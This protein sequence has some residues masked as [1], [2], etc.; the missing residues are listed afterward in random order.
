MPV[1]LRSSR[2]VAP[3]AA[4]VL[5]V[6][7]AFAPLPPA[8]AEQGPARFVF[9]FIGDGMGTVQRRAAELFAGGLAM[10]SLPARGIAT[11]PAA[12]R[13]VTDSAASATALAAGT[14]TNNGMVGVRPDGKSVCTIAE[15]A[16]S[17][18]M[19]VG[20]VTSVPL[21]HATPAGFYAHVPDRYRYHEIA[22][23]LVRSG[24][25]FFGGG[26]ILEPVDGQTDVYALLDSMGYMVV[27][28]RERFLALSGRGRVMAHNPRLTPK[29]AVPWAME[30]DEGR[31][32]TLAEFTQKAVDLLF[33]DKGFFLMVEGGKIDWACHANDAAATVHEVLALDRAVEVALAF[34]EKHPEDTLIVVAADHETGGLELMPHEGGK[35]AAMQVLRRQKVSSPRFREAIISE[36]VERSKGKPELKDFKPLV[37]EFFG[38][39][40]PGAPGDEALLLNPEEV[41][42]IEKAFSHSLGSDWPVLKKL[43]RTV[44]YGKNDP[45]AITLARILGRRAGLRWDTYR[46]TDAPVP[47]SAWGVGEEAFE[48]RYDNTDIATRILDAMGAEAR[49]HYPDPTAVK[50]S[51]PRQGAATGPESGDSAGGFDASCHPNP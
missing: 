23:D 32:I 25:D 43:R 21:N 2:G 12:N 15:I 51:P 47:I 28:N 42:E 37:T 38:L 34:G 11:T 14:K 26:G 31:D 46:H 17:R 18:G 19:K 48:G 27:R 6:V 45:L 41:R 44:Q 5:A 20:I 22:V 9:L 39:R 8:L 40:F 30:L 33:S 4:I 50:A 13:R 16:G 7:L 1:N 3:V 29:H 35:G 10:N 49:V 36:F 24:F